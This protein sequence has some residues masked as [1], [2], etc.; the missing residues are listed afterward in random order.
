MAFRPVNQHPE[1]VENKGC[2]FGFLVLWDFGCFF[3]VVFLVLLGF[4]M[5]LLGF[6][7]VGLC[8]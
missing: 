6:V 5:F 7:F 2:L 1:A 4:C 3:C 8:F